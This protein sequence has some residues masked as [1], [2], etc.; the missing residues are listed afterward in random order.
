[1]SDDDE[2]AHVASHAVTDTVNAK[3]T[4]KLSVYEHYEF[5]DAHS[6]ALVRQC[7]VMAF[8]LAAPLVAWSFVPLVGISGR[9]VTPCRKSCVTLRT[10]CAAMTAMVGW[11]RD[12]DSLSSSEHA[13]ASKG[14]FLHI[15]H[16]T[17]EAAHRGADIGLRTNPVPVR[18]AQLAKMWT[19]RATGLDDRCALPSARSLC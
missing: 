2:P 15:S 10:I 14:G 3:Y 1:M 13:C 11:V 9:C 8:V 16:V 6:F 4:Y 19:G 12:I 7:H 18:A 17:L 5:E